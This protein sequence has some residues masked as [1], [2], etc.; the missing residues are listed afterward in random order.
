MTG[1]GE[2]L[3]PIVR[4]RMAE[5]QAKHAARAQKEVEET[6]ARRAETTRGGDVQP[7]E[8]ALEAAAI[9]MQNGGSTVAADRTFT[10]ILKGYKKAGV[11]AAWR[12]DFIAATSSRRRPVVHGRAAASDP[13]A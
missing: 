3:R 9:V 11:A 2:D 4:A 7:V 1:Y 5:L 13:S 12:L 8:M 10:N 6:P